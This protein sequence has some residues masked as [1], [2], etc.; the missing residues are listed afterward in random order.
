MAFGCQ[1][2]DR[3]DENDPGERSGRIIR[4]TIWVDLSTFPMW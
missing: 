2:I 1:G 3:E 4:F